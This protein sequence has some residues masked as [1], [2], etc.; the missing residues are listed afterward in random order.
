MLWLD[1]ACILQTDVEACLACL[2]IHLA[3]CRRLLVL[4][5]STYTS[6]IWC[7]IELFTFLRMG[8]DLQRVT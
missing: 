8:G 1:K 5:G 3:G 4:A 2:P 6:R 7:M